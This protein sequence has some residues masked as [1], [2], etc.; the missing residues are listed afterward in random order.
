MLGCPNTS[1]SHKRHIITI[2]RN[3]WSVEK[4]TG[5]DTFRWRSSSNTQ[6]AN[7]W[8]CSSCALVEKTRN[9]ASM[10][11]NQVRQQ[12]YLVVIHLILYVPFEPSFP[13]ILACWAF[14]PFISCFPFRPSFWPFWRPF[15]LWPLGPSFF[16][17]LGFHFGFL[18]HSKQRTKKTST[19]LHRNTTHSRQ[20][21][22]PTLETNRR[23]NRHR[24]E[25]RPNIQKGQSTKGRRNRW[26][27]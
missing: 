10:V 3:F 5:W 25:G 22:R 23:R 6:L 19:P 1:A 13:L 16:G 12:H 2:W 21:K 4:N 18:K 14:I 8:I 24:T 15:R 27:R 17:F 26:K 20:A 9:F 7:T 11:N